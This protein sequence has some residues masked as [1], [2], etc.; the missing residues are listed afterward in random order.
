VTLLTTLLALYGS[1]AY[2]VRTTIY[3][4]SIILLFIFLGYKRDFFF[5][6]VFLR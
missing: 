5:F 3:N 2:W 1:A 4:I 6:F